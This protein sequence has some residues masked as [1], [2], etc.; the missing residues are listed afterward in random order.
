MKS[1]NILILLILF[2]SIST[3]DKG[4]SIAQC[5]MKQLGKP[6]KTGGLGPFQFDDFG[7]VYYCMKQVGLSCFVD[8]QTQANQGI[9][10]K[11][12]ELS[13]GDVL[14]AYDRHYNLVGAIIYIGTSQVIYTTNYLNKGVIQ[15]TLSNLNM[16]LHYDYRRNW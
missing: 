5:A 8:R 9:K 3:A 4:L 6:F 1:Y 13:P 12:S 7:L 11:Y 2:I 16:E 14:Y 10:I 15:S